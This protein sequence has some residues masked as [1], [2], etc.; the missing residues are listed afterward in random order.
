[1]LLQDD[2]YLYLVMEYLAGGDVMVI[3]LVPICISTS[4][5]YLIGMGNLCSANI[6]STGLQ[7]VCLFTI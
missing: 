6:L 1:M 3:P 7:C 5:Q 2:E 4:P